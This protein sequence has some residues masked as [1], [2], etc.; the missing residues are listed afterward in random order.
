MKQAVI[1]TGGKQYVVGK[2]DVLDIELLGDQKTVTFDP[3]LVFD[4]ASA[5]SSKV[6]T[7]AVSGHKVKAKVID[8]RAKGKKLKIMKFKAKKR[9]NTRTGH[10]QKY[11][12]VEI[13]SVG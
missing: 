11:A 13:T 10:R 2:G 7:P 3:L 1:E 9:V 8:P 12:R 5:G 4:S 6:G